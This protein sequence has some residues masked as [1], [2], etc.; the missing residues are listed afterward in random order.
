MDIEAEYA[1]LLLSGQPYESPGRGYEA[2]AVWAA[3]KIGG[4]TRLIPEF[5]VM[6]SADLGSKQPMDVL[7]IVPDLASELG[8][9][10]QL[11]ASRPEATK[12][13]QS[14]LT[15]NRPA[16]DELM[17]IAVDI[18]RHGRREDSPISVASRTPALAL[19]GTPVQLRPGVPE[20]VVT[21]LP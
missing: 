7:A 2:L 10:P 19:G 3:A 14:W 1:R 12:R 11:L 15:A 20:M 21:L 8:V 18:A 13:V 5:L 4:D 6:P 17:E 9:E 16:A